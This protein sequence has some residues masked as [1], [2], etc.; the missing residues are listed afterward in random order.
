MNAQPILYAEDE[1]YDVL[2][3]KRAFQLAGVT[4]Q[5][6]TVSDGQLAIDYLSALQGGDPAL[7]PCLILLDLNLPF[8]SGLDVLKWIRSRPAFCTLPV[9]VMSS[10]EQDSD[11]RRAYIH[12]VNG[13]LVKPSNPRDL[14]S[15]V[16]A[17]KDYWLMYNR[18]IEHRCVTSAWGAQPAAVCGDVVYS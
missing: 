13:Y 3:M 7:M 12:G 17:L 9:L 16:K 5:L 11:I 6:V 18:V 10:S 1:E 4:N 14:Q 2:F 15:M 8:K